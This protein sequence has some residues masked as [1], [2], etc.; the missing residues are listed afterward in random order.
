MSG[1]GG[2]SNPRLP[3]GDEENLVS[4]GLCGLW[5]QGKCVLAITQKVKSCNLCISWAKSRNSMLG[6]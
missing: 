6:S 3:D 1:G 5:I 4:F 2:A